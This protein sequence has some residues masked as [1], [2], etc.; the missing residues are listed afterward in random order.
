V[1]VLLAT[2]RPVQLPQALQMTASTSTIPTQSYTQHPVMSTQTQTQT[3]TTTSINPLAASMIPAMLWTRESL[4][5]WTDDFMVDAEKC[6]QRTTNLL[7]CTSHPARNRVNENKYGRIL[8]NISFYYTFDSLPSFNQMKYK[9]YQMK[10]K[11]Y[12]TIDLMIWIIWNDLKSDQ[13]TWN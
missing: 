2:P 7:L 1:I 9:L 8:S 10:C 11:S 13:M 5:L 12:Q 6:S 4:L 3:Q